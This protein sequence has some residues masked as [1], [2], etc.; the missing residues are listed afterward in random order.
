MSRHATKRRPEAIRPRTP[1]T[2]ETSGIS[3]IRYCG[4]KTFPKATNVA[5]PA[6]EKRIR[7]RGAAGNRA[8]A[9][10]N[11]ISTDTSDPSARRAD[12]VRR[13]PGQVVVVGLRGQVAEE[14]VH[15]SEQGPWKTLDLKR[16][17]QLSVQ[18]FENPRRRQDDERRVHNGYHQKRKR[19]DL[20]G[21]APTLAL[22][23]VNH[24]GGQQ[25]RRV[26]LHGDRRAERNS[27]DEPPVGGKR[28]QGSHRER[29]RN[30]IESSERHTSKESGEGEYA[31]DREGRR[32]TRSGHPPLESPHAGEH[33]RR[34]DQHTVSEEELVGG[35]VI[36]DESW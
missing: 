2:R 1:P 23:D 7:V 26:E 20:D 36:A 17:E 5:T 25:H 19:G 9:I 27:G 4:E 28:E 30:E 18:A 33:C 32:H 8:W 3:Q 11:T 6:A 15:S 13:A 21:C 34:S 35:Q 14:A 31:N 16:S 10:H 12:D 22:R 24:D 29:G